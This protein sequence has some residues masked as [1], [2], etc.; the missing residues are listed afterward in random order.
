MVENK[1][2]IVTGGARGMGAGISIELAKK[3]FVVLAVDLLDAKQTLES[4]RQYSPLSSIFKADIATEEG[5]ASIVDFAMKNYGRIDVLVNNVGIFEYAV[6]EDMEEAMW[7]KQIN[8]NLKAMIFLTKAVLPH[9][10]KSEYGRIVNASSIAGLINLSDVGLIAYSCAKA[11][12]SMFTTV[13][14]A[15]VGPYN[16]TVNAYAPGT[17]KTNMTTGIIS[18]RGEELKTRI[19]LGRF[20]EP[21]EV[22]KLVAFLASEDAGYITGE[23]IL[24][25]GGQER[26]QNPQAAL[27]HLR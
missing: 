16:I 15:E 9:M 14:S 21:E 4:I 11:S 19:S 7:D 22:G 23:T 5:R 1:V 25:D 3:G 2:A 24:I 8:V 17:I 10:K 12:V 18:E 26:V 6:L 20:G 27:L 13:L